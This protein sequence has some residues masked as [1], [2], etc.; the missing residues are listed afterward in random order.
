MLYVLREVCFVE[1]LTVIVTLYDPAFDGVPTRAPLLVPRVT[2][3][4]RLPAETLQEKG[5]VPPAT[6][7]VL[8]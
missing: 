6:A 2:P 8:K 7:R 3:A 5:A 1:S 4:G